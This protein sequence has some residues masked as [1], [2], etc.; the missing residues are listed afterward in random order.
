MDVLDRLTDTLN[1]IIEESRDEIDDYEYNIACLNEQ[2]SKKR[3]WILM[4]RGRIGLAEEMLD[5][6]NDERRMSSKTS[7][8]STNVKYTATSNGVPL[9]RYQCVP[10]DQPS[11]YNTETGDDR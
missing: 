11:I 9:P 3:E 1:E 10:P 5:E 6:I 7:A 4:N 2:I 8:G